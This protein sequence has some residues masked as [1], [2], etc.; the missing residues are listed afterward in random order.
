MVMKV[1]MV[2]VSLLL[3]C[4]TLGT[5]RAEAD[6]LPNVPPEAVGAFL[7]RIHSGLWDNPQDLSLEEHGAR[8]MLNAAPDSPDTAKDWEIALS[9]VDVINDAINQPLP[10]KTFPAPWMASIDPDGEFIRQQ[11]EGIFIVITDRNSPEAHKLINIFNNHKGTPDPYLVL[12]KKIGLGDYDKM[13]FVIS[14]NT[15]MS[16][17]DPDGNLT[18]SAMFTPRITA[19]AVPPTFFGRIVEWFKSLGSTPS[20]ISPYAPYYG[21]TD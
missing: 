12:N 19:A 16:A 15:K 17:M 3:S 11:L 10:M 2:A 21:G 4:T 18:R 13:F 6:I 8:A 14:F 20:S 5:V 9:P 7:D 1:Y